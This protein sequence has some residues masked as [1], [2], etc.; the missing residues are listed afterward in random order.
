VKSLATQLEGA[1]GESYAKPE[2]GDVWPKD[3]KVASK[4][5][6]KT[7]PPGEVRLVA[8]LEAR[9]KKYEISTPALTSKDDEKEWLFSMNRELAQLLRKGKSRR[10]LGKMG[11]PAK[12]TETKLRIV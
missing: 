11:K 12:P 10:L 2:P 6:I 1:L 7:G 5:W 3:V 4:R 9:N 8:T